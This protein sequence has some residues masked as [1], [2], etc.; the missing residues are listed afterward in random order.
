MSSSSSSP[1]AFAYCGGHQRAVFLVRVVH[2]QVS[3]VRP[4]PRTPSAAIFAESS[5]TRGDS[6]AAAVR[7]SV[8]QLG[9]QGPGHQRTG[10]R[11]VSVGGMVDGAEVS[12]GG[13]GLVRR[14]YC[15]GYAW[16]GGSTPYKSGV[17][18]EPQNVKTA[19]R[20]NVIMAPPLERCR[21]DVPVAYGSP[22]ALCRA[23]KVRAL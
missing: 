8:F 21:S 5:C 13:S 4:L 6:A 23:L 12:A 2:L 20:Y 11:H 18:A 19:H 1:A 15:S 10:K 22:I 14:H 16:G 17:T 3:G 9:T 7:T